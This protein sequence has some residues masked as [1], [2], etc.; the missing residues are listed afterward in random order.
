ME[1]FQAIQRSV[2]TKMLSSFAADNYFG[3]PV[4]PF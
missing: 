1:R 2:M 3:C 4:E